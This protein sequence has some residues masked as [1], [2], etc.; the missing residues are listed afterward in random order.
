MIF[1]ISITKSAE[2]F[3]K[4]MK[5]KKFFWLL[6]LSVIILV[7][8]IFLFSPREKKFANIYLGDKI[9]KAE[10]VSQAR[11]MA[12]GLSKYDEITENQGMLFLF[13]AKMKP[14]FWMKGMKFAIDI[15]WLADD[16][17]VDLTPNLL[18]FIGDNLPTYQPKE[19]VNKVLEV[20]AGLI[21]K[22]NLKIGDQI[23]IE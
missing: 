8:A 20:K 11:E 9:I 1:K 3:S 6:I 15:I 7:V 5:I 17:I 16:K 14:S 23:V 13:P 4:N 22:N 12:I 19:P 2:I 10:I 18:P 21:E